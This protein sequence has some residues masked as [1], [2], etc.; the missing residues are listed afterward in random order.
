MILLSY[1]YYL[2]GSTEYH[3]IYGVGTY[4]VLSWV[5]RLA[6]PRHHRNGIFSSAR[7]EHEA[8]IGHFSKSYAFFTKYPWVDKYRYITMLNSSAYSFREMA[9]VNI[10]S[11]YYHIGDMEKSMEYYQRT[12]DEFPD[13]E[14][15]RAGVIALSEAQIESSE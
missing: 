5:L 2:F 6:V 10:A 15:A 11:G 13:S 1:L 7:N 9:L 4:L 8:A 12:L 3:L 14:I